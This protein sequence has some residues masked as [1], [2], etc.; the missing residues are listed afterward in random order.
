M[1]QNDTRIILCRIIQAAVIGFIPA[2]FISGCAVS[3]KAGSPPRLLIEASMSGK[4][5]PF[6]ESGRGSVIYIKENAREE[7]YGW[8]ARDPIGLGGYYSEIPGETG[9]DRQQQYLNSL[10]GP[11]GETVFYERIGTCCPFDLFGAPLDKG[12]LDV[13]ALTWEEQTEP[14]HL[15][16]DRFRE[17]PIRI[18]AGLTTKVKQLLALFG[19]DCNLRLP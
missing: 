4:G 10:W 2:L 6:G 18:P 16:L 9:F 19:D 1:N 3:P 14:K 5:W 7:K 12:M 15:Y 17:G 8:T 11:E 13:Y